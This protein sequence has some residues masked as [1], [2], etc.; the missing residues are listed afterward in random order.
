MIDKRV[1]W[2][3]RA[4]PKRTGSRR[5]KRWAKTGIHCVLADLN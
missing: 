3:H 2:P 1:S 4:R 5:P